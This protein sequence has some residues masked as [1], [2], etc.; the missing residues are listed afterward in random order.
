MYT[1]RVVS[2]S[3]TQVRIDPHP[4]EIADWIP[5]N[6]SILYIQGNYFRVQR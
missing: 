6:N 5:K 4:D 1:M 2:K 3:G